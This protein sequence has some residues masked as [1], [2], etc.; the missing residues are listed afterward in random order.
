MGYKLLAVPSGED[1]ACLYSGTVY[2]ALIVHLR[3]VDAADELPLGL[4]FSSI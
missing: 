1:I 3:P 4:F 2:S